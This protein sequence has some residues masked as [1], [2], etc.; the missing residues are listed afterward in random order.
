MLTGLIKKQLTEVF[1]SYYINPKKN[2]ARSKAGTVGMFIL[3]GFL[4]IVVLGGMFAFLGYTMCAPLVQAGV[5][6][7]YFVIFGLIATLL[8]VFGSVFSTFS[9]LYL[10]KDNDLLLSMPIPVR[11]IIL[12]RLAN[13]YLMSLMYVAVV[14]VPVSIVYWIFGVCNAA[15]VV[16]AIVLLLLVSV[17]V[18]LLSCLLGWVV[19]KLS[20]KLKNKSYV[21]VLLALLGIGLYYFLYFK[22]QTL[23]RELVNNAAV[24]GAQVRG[25]ANALYLFGRIGEGDW[26]AMLLFMAVV[27]LLAGLVWLLLRKTFLHIATATGAQ[28]KALY[29]EKTVRQKSVDNALLGKELR[30]FTSSATYMLNCGLGLL[31]LLLGGVLFLVY[32]ERI[33]SALSGM[34]G[35][36]FV[37]V[38][39]CAAVCL[40]SSMNDISAPSV[41]L[42]GKSLWMIQSLPVTPWQVL[43]AKL[44]AHLLIV[45]VPTVFVAVCGAMILR[46]TAAVKLLFELVCLLF[47]LLM[48]LWGLFLGLKLPNLQWTNETFVIKQSGCVAFTL[49]GGWAYPLLLGGLYFLVG[50]SLGPTFYLSLAAAVTA[51]L[52]LVLYLWL[53]TRGARI[54]ATL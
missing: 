3:F 39:L 24:Y 14:L 21:T 31:F 29:R 32:G 43:R 30:R 18:T 40:M 45:C 12:S 23:L 47:A 37:P 46:E 2:E 48:A 20:L 1:R 53:K 4:M 35:S 38:L 5:G 33:V 11:D 51:G 7:L 44:R 42:E 10:A 6:W 54:F 8:G 25:S 41:S 52:D 16:G 34:L 49:F 36:G 22:A 13:V 27:A 28:S 19:A 9:G 50:A 17:F 15:A 26:L